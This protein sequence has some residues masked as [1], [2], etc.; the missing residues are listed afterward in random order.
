MWVFFYMCFMWHSCGIYLMDKHLGGQGGRGRCWSRC[1]CHEEEVQI[2]VM[3]MAAENS[4]ELKSHGNQGGE[5]I[6]L[7]RKLGKTNKKVSSDGPVLFE[8]LCSEIS[9]SLKRT[10]TPS[11]V[12]IKMLTVPSFHTLAAPCLTSMVSLSLLP[13]WLTIFPRDNKLF[14]S[15]FLPKQKYTL[16]L[17]C[18]RQKRKT[19]WTFMSLWQTH[20]TSC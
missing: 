6:Q 5:W 2:E 9:C 12:C 4:Q 17:F 18:T 20:K 7:V 10:Q 11:P 3:L 13:G 15:S 16:F 8:L 14:L 1:R 19:N